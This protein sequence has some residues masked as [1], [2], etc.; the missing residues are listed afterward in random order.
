MNDAVIGFL[1]FDQGYDL[2]VPAQETAVP[3]ISK[4]ESARLIL[5]GEIDC[6][7]IGS[8]THN[9]NSCSARRGQRNGRG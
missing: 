7:K 3:D 6:V 2:S 4:I 1:F 5:Q 8:V 9:I